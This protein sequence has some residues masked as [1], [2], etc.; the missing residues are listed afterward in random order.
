MA[1][2]AS[3]TQWPLTEKVDFDLLSKVDSKGS[4]RQI[5]PNYLR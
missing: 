4:I 2:L 5:P 3:L 1:F